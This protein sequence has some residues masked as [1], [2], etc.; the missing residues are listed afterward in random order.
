M[1]DAI[2]SSLADARKALDTLI[3]REDSQGTIKQAAELLIQT[4][5]S[6]GRV[7]S[8]GN[9]G[10]MCEAMH[11]AEEL[12]GR[13]RDDRS[14]LPAMAISDPS[15]LTCVA[16]DYGYDRVFSR[17]IDAHGRA[18]DCLL[19]LSTSGTSPNV[20]NAAQS[21]RQLGMGVI[22]LT[23]R[24]DSPLGRLADVDIALPVGA[25]GD[26]SQELHLTVIHILIESI[27]RRLFP[28]NY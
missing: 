25:H 16:N 13:F 19:G 6:K 20:L 21:A 2:L 7:Y 18:G 1:A 22:S 5:Q 15:H 12:S 14:A 24:E 8:C 27:E 11:F 9:G 26:R 17:F 23:G 3:A 10:S 28:D 4:F